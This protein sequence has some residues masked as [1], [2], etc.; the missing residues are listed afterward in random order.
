MSTSGRIVAPDSPDERPRA[1]K[2]GHQSRQRARKVIS[3]VLDSCHAGR[4]D[5]PGVSLTP[6]TEVRCSCPC[7]SEGAA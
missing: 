4:H 5:C 2:G 7:H 6:R 3:L 1:D